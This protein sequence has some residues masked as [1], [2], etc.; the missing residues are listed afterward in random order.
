RRR[1]TR[2]SR[3][4]SSD[5]CSSDL[6]RVLLRHG[7]AGPG[8]RFGTAA[9]DGSIASTHGCCLVRQDEFRTCREILY[10]VAHVVR[11]GQSL[12]THVDLAANRR[13]SGEQ[14][15]AAENFVLRGRHRAGLPPIC[16]GLPPTPGLAYPL[17]RPVQAYRLIRFCEIAALR[18]LASARRGCA[19]AARRVTETARGGRE[20]GHSIG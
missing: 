5:V 17:Y 19:K 2:F 1:H 15:Q 13:E 11:T 16:P 3:D 4:W 7:K 8:H 6:D 9:F 18:R 20:P 10:V 14:S 12:P